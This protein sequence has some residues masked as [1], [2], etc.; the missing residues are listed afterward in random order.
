[1]YNKIPT[2]QNNE[3]GVENQKRRR[4]LCCTEERKEANPFEYIEKLREYFN[5]GHGAYESDNE[6]ELRAIFPAGELCDIYN[7]VAVP[8]EDVGG[9]T[10][11]ILA[12]CNVNRNHETTVL[13]KNMQFSFGMFCKNLKRYTE[14]QEQGDRD[15]LTGLYNRNRYERDLSGI[16]ERNRSS[17]ACVYIDANGLHEMNNTKGHDTGDEMLRTVAGKIRR[18]FDTEYIYRTGG[19]EFVLFIPDADEEELRTQCEALSRDLTRSDYHISVGIQRERDIRSISGLIKDA[20]QK[21]YAEKKKY[22][23]EHDRRREPRT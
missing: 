9:N 6:S 3:T 10:C 15:A 1:M 16:Y 2:R 20:E 18:H 17:L 21:M 4:K 14:I 8:V 7:V 19:D 23:Q 13:L 12:V 5:A 22:Y 11:G